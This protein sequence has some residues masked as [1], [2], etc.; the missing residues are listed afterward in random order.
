MTTAQ[1]SEPM[2]P[3]LVGRL[4]QVAVA[5]VCAW[6][7]AQAVPG[8]ELDGPWRRQALVI[9]TLSI[10]D[11]LVGILTRS[12]SKGGA[13]GLLRRRPGVGCIGYTLLAAVTLLSGPVCWWLTARFAE[14]MSWPLRIEGFWPFVLAPLVTAVLTWLPLQVPRVFTERALR[15]V[16]SGQ[17]MRVLAAVGGFWLLLVAGLIRFEA[18]TWWRT[19]ICLVV[20]AS[21]YHLPGGHVDYRADGWPWI[22]VN[23]TIIRTTVFALLF[24]LVVN[25]LLL[26]A[27]EWA[28]PYLGLRLHI[29]GFWTVVTCAAV[30]LLLTWAVS[31][32]PAVRRMRRVLAAQ[33]LTEPGDAVFVDVR[34][35]RHG[36]AFDAMTPRPED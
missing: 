32:P 15:P 17:V 9:I 33:R 20:L 4:W 31:T 3:T 22:A 29:D 34:V 21:L 7:A 36:F 35:G 23:R 25:A 16:L 27:V 8:I 5:A 30:L 2:K 10:L 28:S 18:G 13:G 12:F 14:L 6:G 19:A 1:I 11:Q 24:G 26:L